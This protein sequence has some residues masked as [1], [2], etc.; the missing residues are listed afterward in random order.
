MKYRIPV[1][2]FVFLAS[3]AVY[4]CYYADDYVGTY[5]IVEAQDPL[6]VGANVYVSENSV[7]IEYQDTQGQQQIV[8]Y[9]VV[10]PPG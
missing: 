1:W 4:P 7:R 5:T 8:E 6:L 9:E 2:T 3:C 10:V